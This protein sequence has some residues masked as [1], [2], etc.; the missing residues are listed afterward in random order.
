LSAHFAWSAKTTAESI[1]KS[2]REK[3]KALQ[4]IELN[5]PEYDEDFDFRNSEEFADNVADMVEA[6]ACE[7]YFQNLAD[8]II[9][10]LKEITL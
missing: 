9:E 2:A 7:I 8:K 4:Q 3:A 5:K 1:W 10:I 6:D